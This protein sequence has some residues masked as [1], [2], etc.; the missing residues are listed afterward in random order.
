M[1][2]VLIY[3][4]LL[5]IFVNAISLK[6]ARREANRSMR[7]LKQAGYNYM[8]TRGTLLKRGH[9]KTFKVFFYKGNSYAIFG[10]GDKS[11]KDLDVQ[12]YDKDWNV[13][14]E[15]YANS[16]PIYAVQV[17]PEQTG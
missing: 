16:G 10:T 12:V 15:D 11:V 3:I 7:N 6:E 14:A 13:V 17:S 5:T 1:I 9:Y 4:L 8:S 2:R